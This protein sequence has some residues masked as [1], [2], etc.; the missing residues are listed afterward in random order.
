MCQKDDF[1]EVARKLKESGKGL[2]EEFSPQFATFEE[3]WEAM[4]TRDLEYKSL[5]H[6]R[7][8][9]EAVLPWMWSESLLSSVG[10]PLQLWVLLILS[11]N[12]PTVP[13]SSDIYDVLCEES[14]G[15]SFC[16]PILWGIDRDPRSCLEVQGAGDAWD[17]SRKQLKRTTR[18]H[19]VTRANKRMATVLEGLSYLVKMDPYWWTLAKILVANRFQDKKYRFLS[20][21]VVYEDDPNV[22]LEEEAKALELEVQPGKCKVESIKKEPRANGR[23]LKETSIQPLEQVSATTNT[24][25]SGPHTQTAGPSNLLSSHAPPAL[26]PRSL[27]SEAQHSR[28]SSEQKEAA[29]AMVRLR[30][31]RDL[32]GSHR[33]AAFE[34]FLAQALQADTLSKIGDGKIDLGT[35]GLRDKGNSVARGKQSART[36]SDKRS[37]IEGDDEDFEG[38]PFKKARQS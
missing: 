36:A 2:W 34:A 16:C 17:L 35:L 8:T 24:P 21:I 12:P 5:L 37:R 32:V 38:Q 3:R 15:A 4:V 10:G 26:H 18:S 27:T 14:V 19:F 1:V 20:G 22:F 28:T 23:K 6:S 25:T 9:K 30:V 29:H 13:P 7:G 11:L 31:V 33:I